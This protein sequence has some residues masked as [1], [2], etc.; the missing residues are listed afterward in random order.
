VAYIG[1]VRLVKSTGV[2]L[3]AVALLVKTV[4]LVQLHDHVLLQPGATPDSEAYFQLA[5]RVIAGDWAL[6]PGAYFVSPLYIY[7][8]ALVYGTCDALWAVK[9]VQIGLGSAAVWLI[10]WTTQAWF[11]QRAALLAGIAAIATGLFTF[12]EVSLLQAA[13]DPFLTATTLAALTAGLVGRS[14]LWFVVTGVAAAAQILN[15]PNVLLAAI[16]I[17]VVLLLVRRFKPAGLMAV[18]LVVGLLPVAARNMAATD[19]LSLLPSHGGIAFYTGNAPDANGLYRQIPGIRASILGQAVDARLVAET[20]SG[21]AMSDAEVSSHFTALATDWMAQDPGAWVRLMATKLYYT[22]HGQHFAVPLS[23]PFFAYDTGAWLAV[24]ALGPWLLFSLGTWGLVF[25]TKGRAWRWCN[26]APWAIATPALVLSVALFFVTER[27]RLP[28]LVP[29]VVGTGAALSTWATWLRGRQWRPLAIGIGAVAAGV[30]AFNQRLDMIDADGRME[31]RVKMAE[32]SARA[33]D[34]AGAE[35][36]LA[37]SLEVYPYPASAHLRLATILADRGDSGAAVQHLRAAPGAPTD[38][39]HPD[40][41]LQ[42]G[43]L[44][45]RL[46]AV[47]VAV[48]LFRRAVA[49]VPSSTAARDQLAIALMLAGDLDTART[50]FGVVV[51]AD[52]G[53]ADAWAH[54][55]YIDAR[56]GAASDALGHA[57]RALALDPTHELATKVVAAITGK[58]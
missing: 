2:R 49:L 34:R 37:M 46:E 58:P 8:L 11:D 53:N 9:A 1:A 14:S 13:L 29:L 39:D 24:L 52:P 36:W 22:L 15:R 18:G 44:A 23:Y 45:I 4:V 17:L 19:D 30:F 10:W 56:R 42:S 28:V 55:A 21:R 40:T 43:R 41:W 6:G 16:A 33:G 7:F 38:D 32:A 48:D 5:Q 31:E 20:A 51:R 47:D 50:E 25:A 26:F 3:A 35:R 57:N 27:Y 54:L 12:Y